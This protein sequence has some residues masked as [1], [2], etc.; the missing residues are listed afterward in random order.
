M[1]P[2][3]ESHTLNKTLSVRGATAYTLAWLFEQL[4]PCPC[5][6]TDQHGNPCSRMAAVRFAAPFGKGYDDFKHNVDAR[7]AD[8]E[9]DRI[10]WCG[11][12]VLCMECY[13]RLL[14]AAPQHMT[15]E[16]HSVKPRYA[17]Q[18]NERILLDTNNG[19][20]MK[21]EA[22][23]PIIKCPECSQGY[24]INILKS[25][26]AEAFLDHDPR[27]LVHKPL[28][29]NVLLHPRE[30]PSADLRELHSLSILVHQDQNT[31]GD[32]V[33]GGI[34]RH[35]SDDSV[36]RARNSLQHVNDAIRLS[37]AKYRRFQQEFPAW[38]RLNAPNWDVLIA[39]DVG[40]LNSLEK[41]TPWSRGGADRHVK[42]HWGLA[43]GWRHRL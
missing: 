27:R 17:A 15:I 10:L 28:Y 20:R 1:V 21:V 41:W 3:S 26:T 29:T 7:N 39:E 42:A 24:K 13:D 19:K 4:R 30:P 33:V 23:H 43:R 18:G 2:L 37:H 11:H 12:R 6:G 32:D 40:M 35:L 16:L 34:R 9:A 25:W 22:S 5:R 36:L 8:N 14:K 31:I 38:V